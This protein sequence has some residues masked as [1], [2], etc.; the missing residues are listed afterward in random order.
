MTP[1]LCREW[2]CRPPCNPRMERW[3]LT[4]ICSANCWIFAA[5]VPRAILSGDGDAAKPVGKLT[6][7]EQLQSGAGLRT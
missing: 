3:G 5:A 1:L 7:E 4:G 6:A 2:G